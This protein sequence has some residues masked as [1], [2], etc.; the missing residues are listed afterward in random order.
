MH[1]WLTTGQSVF[2]LQETGGGALA[3][4]ASV[5]EPSCGAPASPA[6]P[7][8]MLAPSPAASTEVVPASNSGAETSLAS[9]TRLASS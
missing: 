7:S 6:L 2:Q 9:P 3:S 8:L 1:L 5:A 4:E